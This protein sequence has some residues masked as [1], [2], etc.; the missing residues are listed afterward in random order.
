[1]KSFTTFIGIMFLTGCVVGPE[2]KAPSPVVPS[3]F[4]SAREDTDARFTSSGTQT[5]QLDWWNAFDDTMLTSVVEMALVQNLD[6]HIAAQRV[7]ASRAAL[8]QTKSDYFPKIGFGADVTR[9]SVAENSA[10]PLA[11]LSTLSGADL[12]NNA[13]DL[14]VN[15]KWEL[16]LFGAIQRS[17]EASG[18]KM[19]ATT[20][21]Y[22]LVNVLI[23]SEI[24]V[25]YFQLRGLQRRLDITIKNIEVLSDTLDVVNKK[26]STG[27]VAEIDVT[28][29]RANLTAAK[30][31]LPSIRALI[32]QRIFTLSVLVGRPPMFLASMLEAHRALPALP[33]SIG[34]GHPQDLLKIRPD[35]RMAE[36]HLAASSAEI[37][38]AT[39]MLY[40]KISLSGLAGLSSLTSDKVFSGDSETWSIR[41]GVQ[42]P[43]FRMGEL[44]AGVDA[45][46][47]RFEGAYL[48]YQHVVLSALQE[49]ESNLVSFH[50]EQKR[51]AQLQQTVLSTAR[52]VALS[53]VLYEKGLVDF[54]T[55]L[56]AER[57]LV[58]V[59]DLHAQSETR[60]FVNLVALH[61]SLG[62][63]WQHNAA[64]HFPSGD[65]DRVGGA[66]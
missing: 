50:E 48:S 33:R 19:Q 8:T 17:V 53:K 46:K 61:K 30:S 27:L 49:V 22:H 43:L 65:L 14:G 24:G 10:S 45:A 16:D 39:A 25:H 7:V 57:S 34:L 11:A 58:E 12:T 44:K 62:G 66:Q 9:A 1:M 26:Y 63:S 3:E 42:W 21:Q 5:A 23:A 52:T 15:S 59:E 13:F 6:I 2:Y 60:Q 47:A 55:V 35:I 18:A 28:R 32:Q 37:G 54:L 31:R 36:R 64:H 4:A 40:P 38:V 20:E 41:A 51:T 56:D 29:A